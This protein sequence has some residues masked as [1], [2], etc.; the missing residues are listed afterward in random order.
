MR[1]L[2]STGHHHIECGVAE[3]FRALD[4]V[5]RGGLFVWKNL[6]SLLHLVAQCKNL[7]ALIAITGLTG[8]T[9][10][11]GKDPDEKKYYWHPNI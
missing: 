1:A 5:D 4:L 6:F 3:P 8:L 9:A 2:A 11:H 10:L 7:T